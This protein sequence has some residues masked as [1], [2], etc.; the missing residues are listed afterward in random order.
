MIKIVQNMKWG[1]H[2]WDPVYLICTSYIDDF[3]IIPS[4]KYCEKRCSINQCLVGCHL[5]NIKKPKIEKCLP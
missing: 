2:R 3:V 1:C 5:S 4:E